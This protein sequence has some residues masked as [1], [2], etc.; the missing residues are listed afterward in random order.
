[1]FPYDDMFDDDLE[2]LP[3]IS[4]DMSHAPEEDDDANGRRLPKESATEF[5]SER[6]LFIHGNKDRARDIQ[7]ILLPGPNVNPDPGT[8]KSRVSKIVKKEP[9]KVVVVDIDVEEDKE[10]PDEILVDLNKK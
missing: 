1:M 2:G 9:D 7:P 8:G 4:R 6:H 3:F 5:D 10:E